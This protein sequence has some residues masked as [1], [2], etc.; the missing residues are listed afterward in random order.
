MRLFKP[1]SEFVWLAEHVAA[2]VHSNRRAKS[3]HG[4]ILAGRRGKPRSAPP[5]KA[6][7]FALKGT[8]G[9]LR[10]QRTW[11]GL[12]LRRPHIGPLA[13]D[14]ISWPFPA[15]APVPKLFGA[16]TERVIASDDKRLFVFFRI[17]VPICPAVDRSSMFR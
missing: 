1:R 13:S 14:S 5:A 10:E 15:G 11:C 2:S 9:D 6:S 4:I 8:C 12:I 7:C 17:A 3:A 16:S